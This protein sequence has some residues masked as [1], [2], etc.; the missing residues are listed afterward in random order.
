[1]A[2]V[3]T[4]RPAAGITT[5]VEWTAAARVRSIV[6]RPTVPKEGIGA[7]ALALWRD[8]HRDV[9]D[10]WRIAQAR[11]TALIV[12]RQGIAVARRDASAGWRY[13]MAVASREDAS[14]RSRQ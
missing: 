4:R 10:P 2:A 11:D 8:E 12:P 13:A 1:M 6:L 5:F 14:E 3:Y 9:A 7:L